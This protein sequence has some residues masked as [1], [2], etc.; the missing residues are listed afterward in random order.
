MIRA[1]II[2]A[3]DQALVSA[4]SFGLAILLI[5]FG[6]KAEYGL[7]SQLINLQ[8]LFSPL[9]AGIFAS[10]YLA[11]ASKMDGERL[12]EYRTAMARAEI[13][14][15]TLWAAA[16]IGAFLA[17]GRLF[18]PTITPN[19]SW[20]FGV[21]LLA[22]W[23][24][25]FVRQMKFA[26]MQYD[27]ALR[28]DITYVA[29]T[30]ACTI[31]ALAAWRVTSSSV[32]WSM[33]VGGCLASAVPLVSAIRGVILDDGAVRR[34]VIAS[35]KV[36]RWEA[37][38][39]MVSWVYAQSYVYFAALHSGLDGA[40]EVSAGRLL[41]TPLT[42]MW[43]S[44]ANVLRPNAS[45]LLAGDS[46]LEIRRLAAR[47]ALFVAGSSLCYALALFAVIPVLNQSLFGGKFEHLRSL[48]MWWIVYIMLAGLSTVASSVLRSALEF[49]QVFN[50]QAASCAAA[51]ILLTLALK[52][53][54]LESL[55]MAL[56]IVEAISA[57]LF[58][59]RLD[60]AMSFQPKST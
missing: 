56:V 35:W 9:H 1:T 7:F 28:V 53:P 24:R 20:S 31:G 29:V 55:V 60:A 12:L 50:R 23:W 19:V 27:Q 58:W 2:S 57:A 30:A 32:L 14:M 44:Y 37:M 45:R 33:A 59:H 41:G 8:S 10:A 25:E 21:A 38:G 4:L 13:G 54:A 36:G 18:S 6:S 5:H 17:A 46:R 15:T 34:D 42:L 51:V 39:S 43:A 16:V 47:S 49:R 26:A 52:V 22:L 11:L 40:A 3:V 48:S